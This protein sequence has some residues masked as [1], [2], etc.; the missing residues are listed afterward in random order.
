M[1]VR[2]SLATRFALFFTGALI[3]CIL[4]TGYLVFTKASDVIVSY[5]KE[6]IDHTSELAEQSFLSLLKE[7]SDDVAIIS[8]SPVLNNYINS[9]TQQNF[10]DI[11]ELF[12][13]TLE[14]KLPYFQIRFIGKENGGQE[15]IRFDKLNDSI[16]I[17]DNL[18]K[19][20]D[21]DY[22]QET[23]QMKKGQV[24]LSKINL[25]EEYGTIS[26]PVTP[27]VRAAS[28]IFNRNNDLVGI[29]VINV[30]LISFYRDLERISGR[31]SQ[32]LLIDAEGQYLYT[33]EYQKWFAFQTGKSYNYFTDF[34]IG[35]DSVI[36]QASFFGQIKDIQN[37]VYLCGLRELIYFHGSRKIYLIS[38]IEQ[39]ILLQ[40]ARAVRSDSLKTSLWVC[41]FAIVISLLFV[42][43]F[44][45]KIRQVTKA[46]ADYEDGGSTDIKLPTNR[47]DEIGVLANTFSKMKTKIDQKVSELNVALQKEQHAKNQRDEFLQNM[48][49]E[50]RTPL[51]TIL[52]LTKL[53]GKQSPKKAQI[54]ILSSLEK[55]AQNLEG[56]VYDVLDHQ[57]LVE[58][59]LKINLV[60][61]NL[62]ELFTDIH[63]NYKY[64]ALRKGLSFRLTVDEEINGN[65]YLT[66]PLRLSQIVTNLVVNAIKYTQKGEIELQAGLS[67]D[68]SPQLQVKIRDTGIGIEA[69]NLAK[70]NERFYREKENIDGRYGG[71]G[72]GLS[73][74]KQLT[75]LFGGVLSGKST[76]GKG[77]EFILLIPIEKAGPVKKDQGKSKRIAF[78]LLDKTYRVLH[79]EDDES[80][81]QLTKHVL[82]DRSI[83][84]KQTKSWREASKAIS[85]QE[86]DLIISDLMLDDNN[87]VTSL[88]D[89]RKKGKIDCP[90]LVVSALEPLV[91]RKVSNHYLQKPFDIDHFK[92]VVYRILG[93]NEINPPDFKPFYKNYDK[94][95]SK[96]NRVLELLEKEFL[97]YSKR[98]EKVYD[99]K[100]QKE[101]EAISH[102]L[103]A[104][105]NTLKLEQLQKLLP[106]EVYQLKET[107]LKK[108]MNLFNYYQV[109]IR[110]ERQINST[111][112]S[113]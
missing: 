92:D 41:G 91:M 96:I 29:L 33:P 107:E 98:I 57:K 81:Q 75:T 42:N 110:C 45:K 105:I 28:P 30:D 18:Q 77:S 102:K 10:G 85:S 71:Y 35:K 101:Y 60:P 69:D 90:L 74:V 95:T 63:Q 24:Y 34:K 68:I 37:N 100:N 22:Y 12:R 17:P 76:K 55:S 14:N 72:L 89:L 113:Y 4:L 108:I 53:L 46:I 84:L 83:E 15:L 67:A 43:I 94:D 6:R 32:L 82:D 79:I 11:K 13:L 70:I 59:K 54:P 66:D 9:P 19:K 25:N 3:F 23:I 86:V 31:E 20:G 5:S 40:S 39:D 47:K 87:L 27:T 93:S 50:M 49:H 99:I 104:H 97:S 8:S 61:T 109:C 26:E 88:T 58:G 56:L 80:T 78:P 2:Y 52:G 44:S 7:V 51:N 73:I 111:N 62:V 48:S 16:F 36:N 1:N 21:L 64:E 38:S 106:K 103:I 112:Q 65:S